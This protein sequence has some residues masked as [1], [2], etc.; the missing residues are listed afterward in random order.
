[1]QFEVTYRNQVGACITEIVEAVDR[2][3]CFEQ[4]RARKITPLSVKTSSGTVSQRGKHT[5][6]MARTAIFVSIFV[7]V[8]ITFVTAWIICTDDKKKITTTLPVSTKRQSMTKVF[9]RPA[10]SDVPHEVPESHPENVPAVSPAAPRPKPDYVTKPLGELTSR[11]KALRFQWLAQDTNNCV[12]GID[13]RERVPPPVYSNIIQEAIAP[14]T[15]PG[16][17]CLPF[18]PISDEKARVAIATKIY[19]NENDSEELTEQKKTVEAI[20][21]ELKEYM[22]NGGH[23]RDYFAKLEERQQIESETMKTVRADIMRMRSEG[24]WE[25]A[26]LAQDEYNKYLKSKG[27]PLLHMRVKPGKKTMEKNGDK[28]K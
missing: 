22:D 1:M 12:R 17:D 21:R 2:N 18:P 6:K 23:A 5:R 14:Y 27:L 7:L 13:M 25:G 10:K 11:E 28:E 24:D 9:D 19:F 15:I 8:V 16:A 20:L 4:L 26:K 3:A